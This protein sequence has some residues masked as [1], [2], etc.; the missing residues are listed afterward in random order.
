MDSALTKARVVIG[1]AA[2]RA[3]CP[4]IV[5]GPDGAIA[6]LTWGNQITANKTGLENSG[7][8]SRNNAVRANAFT[9]NETG[10]LVTDAVATR[11]EAN[12]VFAN[13]RH[14]IEL[15]G[16]SETRLNGNVITD[17]ADVGVRMA[18]G[19]TKSEVIANRIQGN[20]TGV[21]V[22]GV[23]TRQHRFSANTI[24]GNTGKGIA[25]IGGSNDGNEEI[26]VMTLGGTNP[27]VRLTTQSAVEGD[28]AWSPYGQRIAFVS[29]RDGNP[30]IYT[31]RSDGSDLRRLT[32]HS[33]VDH[34]PAW[35]AGSDTLAFSS[36]R[37]EGFALY[38]L[39]S[40]GGG[41]DRLTLSSGDNLQPAASP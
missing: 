30:E 3:C 19:A 28:P 32:N 11:L 7:L 13:T 4:P 18:G 17:N 22:N 33:A 10:V 8:A 6:P 12:D 37:D 15:T 36:N 20:Q 16:A 39:S 23:T 27:I 14:G 1:S 5:A 2:G 31:V 29:E 26:Y 40:Q 25:L 35:L 21:E 24:S 9:A 38:L 41:P 34:S